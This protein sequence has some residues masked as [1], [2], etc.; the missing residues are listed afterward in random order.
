MSKK[1]VGGNLKIVFSLMALFL[2]FDFEFSENQNLFNPQKNFPKELF[3]HS[4]HF[5]EMSLTTDR[6]LIQ[7]E[8]FHLLALRAMI[9]AKLDD[10][11]QVEKDSKKM[12]YMTLTDDY[13]HDEFK[14]K[15]Q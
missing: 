10:R 9:S 8:V 3:L 12:Y 13:L 5:Y 6:E 2:P 14:R 15:Y 11:E 7:L 4:R 1:M